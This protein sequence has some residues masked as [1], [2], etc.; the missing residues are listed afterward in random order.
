MFKTNLKTI[1]IAVVTVAFTAGSAFA[2]DGKACSD[3]KHTAM[4]T[5][6]QTMTTQTTVASATQKAA[7]KGKMTYLSFDDALK[8]CQEKGAADL[9]ACVDYKTGVKA[10]PK[11]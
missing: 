6:T 11:S 1:S 10:K 2:G 7:V 9:Q 5:Q 8:L 4:K 3:K